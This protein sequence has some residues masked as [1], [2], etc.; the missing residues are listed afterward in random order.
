MTAKKIFNK[1]DL[2][3]CAN[4]ETKNYLEKL[5]AKNIRYFGNIKFFN[6]I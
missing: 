3:L 2:F 1:F 4:Q 6:E 5:S